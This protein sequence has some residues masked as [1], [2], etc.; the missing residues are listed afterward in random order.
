[1]FGHR[2]TGGI[3]A[4]LAPA[5]AALGLAACLELESAYA[6]ETAP[7]RAAVHVALL[8]FGQEV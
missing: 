7:A 4:L 3:W 6:A 2:H 1:M 8:A 5:P